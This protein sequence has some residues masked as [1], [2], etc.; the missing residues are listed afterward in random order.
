MASLA[1]LLVAATCGLSAQS[2]L[3]PV[4][5]IVQRSVEANRRD[6]QAAARYAYSETLR[7][8]D[9][10][11]TFDVDVIDGTPYRRLVMIDGQRLS[12]NDAH[13]EAEKLERERVTRAAESR[14]V[15]DR[16]IA[17][18]EKNRDRVLRLLDEL[19]RAF[20]YRLV[21]TA[22]VD[23]RPTLLLEGTARA[24]YVP[25]TIDAGVLRAARV[26][27]WIDVASYHWVRVRARVL[28]PVTLAGFL[29]AVQPGTEFTLDEAPVADGVWL[30]SHFAMRT[31]SAILSLIP[32]HSDDT[33]TYFDYHPSGSTRS[34][35]A[36]PVSDGTYR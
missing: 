35:L 14:Q 17:G 9:T 10:T 21:S 3:P 1:P 19:P 23:G 15:R 4:D 16:R 18:Y 20:E 28:R 33:R 5:T 24:G 7:D 29:V 11:K 32:H 25:P 27:F 36:E 26:E 12:A 13:H 8:G 30:P 2:G 31:R 34:P 22:A 6:V